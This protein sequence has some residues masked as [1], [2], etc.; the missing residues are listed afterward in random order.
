LALGYYA[1]SGYPADDKQG[2]FQG[3]LEPSNWLLNPSKN[4]LSQLRIGVYKAYADHAAPEIVRC[5]Y[6]TLAKYQ[7][8]G[9]TIVEIDIPQLE[10]SRVAH[11]GIIGSELT[12][13]AEINLPQ[14]GW[15]RHFSA[16]VRLQLEAFQKYTA[17]V[18]SCRTFI[19]FVLY[20]PVVSV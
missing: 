3:P 12:N 10:E 15:R 1:M 2:A 14:R 11:L 4:D 9:A 17:M 20:S 7:A 18:R 19:D 5:F 13:F 8:L 6:A 16:P